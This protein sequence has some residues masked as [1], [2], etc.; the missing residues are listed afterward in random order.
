LVALPKFC[1]EETPVW[2]V[3]VGGWGIQLQSTSILAA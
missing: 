3:G 1:A 2:E